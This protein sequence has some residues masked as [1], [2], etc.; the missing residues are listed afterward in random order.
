MRIFKFGGASVKDAA[1]V[2]NL[3]KILKD[4]SHDNLVVIVSAMG[5]STNLLENL[6]R[7]KFEGKDF[8]D[9]LTLFT[10]F[11]NKICFDLFAS[12]PSRVENWYIQLNADLNNEQHD[13][14]LLHDKI[15]SYGE[16]ISTTIIHEFL[17]LEHEFHW[18][19]VRK[20]IRTNSVFTEAN[21]DWQLTQHFINKEVQPLLKRKSVITQGYIGA[22]FTGN[23][24]TL[25]REGSDYTGAVF[26]HCLN[27][28]S[29]TVWKDV[30]G[31]LNADPKIFPSAEVFTELSFQEVTE[32]TYYGAKVI[33]PKTIRPLA[34][35]D[36]PL[37]VRSFLDMQAK[38]TKISNMEKVAD[39]PCFVF[40]DDQ[41]LV[42]LRVLDTSL[43]DEKKMVK[44][45]QSLD[46]ANIK[47]NLMH[48]S[49]LTFSFCMDADKRK[50]EKVSSYLKNDF[51][52]L[53][54]DQLFLAT[55]KNFDQ[56]SFERLPPMMEIIMEQK[57]RN[58]YQVIYRAK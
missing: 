54:N 17:S 14:G 16:L 15:V 31:L 3:G 41:C 47:I 28:E 45:F 10:N 19:D 20:V 5:K 29:L 53:Y 9:K 57:T 39:I 23:T 12:I 4:Q 32:L 44:I 46:Q 55:I 40:K 36:I 24:T 51:Q 21:V 58:N 33:H 38:G 26:A 48:T 49:A 27:A 6:V 7:L 37:F 1:G 50:M 30:P 13:Y 18:L 11:H 8:H 2:R 34:Q 43:M 22:D 56:R 35:K 25:G 52:I 42:T